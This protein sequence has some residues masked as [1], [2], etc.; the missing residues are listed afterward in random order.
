MKS[1]K[2]YLFIM[3]ALAAVFGFVACGD[4]DPSTVAEYK[5]DYYGVTYMVTFL[6]DDTWSQTVE[7]R[8]EKVTM[9]E[10]T[11]QGDPSTDGKIYITATKS[12]NTD[13][14]L[15]EVP[16]DYRREVT[17]TIASKKFTYDFITYTRQ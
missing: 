14:K 13:E 3:A 8:G 15:T 6:D 17:I 7:Y 4:D 10:G 1:I 12:L 5:A 9:A 16:K 11:Y 2:K